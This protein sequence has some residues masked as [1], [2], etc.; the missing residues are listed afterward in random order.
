MVDNY[1]GKRG[2]IHITCMHVCTVCL[3]QKK[4]KMIGEEFVI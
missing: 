4:K 3:L 1:G 2:L